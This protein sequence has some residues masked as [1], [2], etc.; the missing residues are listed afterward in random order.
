ML[1][2]VL[3]DDLEGWGRVGWG[4]REAQEE[5]DIYLHIAE[6]FPCTTEVNTTLQS[7]YPPIKNE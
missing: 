6:S 5:G 7:N 2:S 4:G 1:S 3:S